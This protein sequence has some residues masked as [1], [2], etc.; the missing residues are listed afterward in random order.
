MAKVPPNKR[1]RS[2]LLAC[3]PGLLLGCDDASV[4]GN[5]A[6]S[7]RPSGGAELRVDDVCDPECAGSDKVDLHISYRSTG[8]VQQH[9]VELVQYRVDYALTG[10]AG[11]V[12]FYGGRSSF[13]VAPGE[14]KVQSLVVVGSVQRDFVRSAVGGAAVTGTA[15]LTL[16]GYDHDNHQIF[17]DTSFVVRFGDETLGGA[18]TGS[19]ADGD[20][21]GGDAT[22]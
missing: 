1:R 21:G 7:A 13:E 19:R 2:W 22:K 4:K 10:V 16:A 18:A 15:T 17:L 12:P 6:L 9:K 20:A 5:L 11:A 3:W 14:D 8:S